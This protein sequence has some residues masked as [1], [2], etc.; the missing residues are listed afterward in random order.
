MNFNYNR[1]QKLDSQYYWGKPEGSYNNFD[2]LCSL[3][4]TWM[5]DRDFNVD[6]DGWEMFQDIK[7]IFGD[8]IAN[9]ALQNIFLGEHDI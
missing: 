4:A 8:P 7:A 5:Y 6:E 2:Y 9:Q 1:L 3:L